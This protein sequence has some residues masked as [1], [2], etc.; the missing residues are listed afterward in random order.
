MRTLI[1]VSKLGRDPLEGRRPLLCAGCGSHVGVC[2]PELK[3]VAAASFKTVLNTDIS[4]V[5]VRTTG[6]Y[7][8]R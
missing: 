4:R 2:G 6:S 3:C 1:K 8:L 5:N 7:G